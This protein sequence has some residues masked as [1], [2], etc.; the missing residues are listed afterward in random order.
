[1]W[2]LIYIGLPL[3]SWQNKWRSN[4]LI[5]LL[6]VLSINDLSQHTLLFTIWMQRLLRR[7]SLRSSCFSSSSA[8]F[9]F[10]IRLLLLLFRI[11]SIFSKHFL[12]SVLLRFLLCFSFSS[13]SLSYHYLFFFFYNYLL[14]LLLL[15]FLNFSSLFGILWYMVFSLIFTF[16]YTY[17]VYF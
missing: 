4:E 2:S 6:L 8:N 17:R 13:N 11:Y 12:L 9:F 14:L 7:Y 16:W 10:A 1:M 5:V 15:L 3:D